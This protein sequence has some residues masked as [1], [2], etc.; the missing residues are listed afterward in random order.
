MQIVVLS[1]SL[2]VG[3]MAGKMSLGEDVYNSFSSQ[4]LRICHEWL[5]EQNHKRPQHKGLNP[6]Q[7]H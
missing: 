7:P 4:Y 3:F 6:S 1:V 5:V 2:I